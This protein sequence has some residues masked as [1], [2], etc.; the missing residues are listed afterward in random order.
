MYVFPVSKEMFQFRF[1]GKLFGVNYSI[2]HVAREDSSIYPRSEFRVNHRLEHCRGVRQ[3]KK[4]D[5]W[6]EEALGCEEGSFPFVA[7]SDLDIVISLSDVELREQGAA[8]QSINNF[9]YQR[10]D[11]PIAD[12][13]FVQWPIILH[14]L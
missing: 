8:H 11:I 3:A 13:P 14:R 7:F 10:R 1:V 5:R 9:G 12:C 4:H 6:F 2:I